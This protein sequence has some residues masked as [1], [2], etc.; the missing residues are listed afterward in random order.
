MKIKEKKGKFGGKYPLDERV[1]ES[2]LFNRDVIESV[3]A[4][5]ISEEEWPLS[6]YRAKTY[7]DFVRAYEYLCVGKVCDFNAASIISSRKVKEL[8]KELQEEAI[9]TVATKPL[10]EPIEKL[11]SQ[12][13]AGLMGIEKNFP[14]FYKEISIGFVDTKNPIT[15]FHVGDELAYYVNWLFGLSTAEKQ[16]A[17]AVKLWLV[18]F[19]GDD[20]RGSTLLKEVLTDFALG[21]RVLGYIAERLVIECK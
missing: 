17:W 19:L 15:S 14:Q 1:V 21:N 3:C 8:V 7:L 9:V 5:G 13:I 18:A 20:E 11:F 10:Y 2:I 12:T 4:L 16:M 6:N